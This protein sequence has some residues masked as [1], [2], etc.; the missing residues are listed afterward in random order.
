MPQALLQLDKA[1]VK[2]SSSQALITQTLISR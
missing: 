1:D 2:A